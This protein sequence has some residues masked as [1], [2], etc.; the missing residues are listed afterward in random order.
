MTQLQRDSLVDVEEK[1][2]SKPVPTEPEKEQ[3]QYRINHNLTEED[4]LYLFTDILQKMSHKVYTMTENGTL[5]DLNDLDPETFWKVQYFTQLFMENHE[6]Q[7]ETQQLIHENEASLDQFKQQIDKELKTVKSE[8]GAIDLHHLTEYERLRIQALSQCPY[9]IYADSNVSGLVGEET[10]VIYSDNFQHKW[11]QQNKNDEISL[12]ITKIAT[13][14]DRLGSPKTQIIEKESKLA[15]VA[16]E[17][18]DGNDG[19]DLDA[20]IDDG[21]ETESDMMDDE[22]MNREIQTILHHPSNVPK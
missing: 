21:S 7:K 17:D 16:P 8:T 10:K 12:K 4:H 1:I 6:R 3:L 11:K 20:N 15:S 2:K 9:S 14:Y 13:K 5:F 19:K 18:T 22:T